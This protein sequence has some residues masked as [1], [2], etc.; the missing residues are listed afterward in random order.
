MLNVQRSE[1][2]RCE[3]RKR[4]TCCDFL[5]SV[6]LSEHNTAVGQFKVPLTHHVRHRLF[7]FIAEIARLNVTRPITNRIIELDHEIRFV[8]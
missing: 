5:V 3:F 7:A 8:T 4:I 6:Y 2:N 1:V